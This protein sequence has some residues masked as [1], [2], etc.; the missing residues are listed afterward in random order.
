M[1]FREVRVKEFLRDSFR[2]GFP[3]FIA[4]S[5]AICIY[6]FIY[7]FNFVNSGISNIIKILMPFVYG[8]VIAY[9]LKRPYNF[10][11]EKMIKLLSEKRK[12]LAKLLAVI[13]VLVITIAL[14]VVLLMLVI[15]ALADS[16]VSIANQIPGLIDDLTKWLKEIDPEGTGIGGAIIQALETA[17]ENAVPWLK[18]NILSNISTTLSGALSTVT[19]ILGLLYNILIGVIICIYV[20]LG[21]DT[22]ARQ[23]KMLV[24][25]TFSRKVADWIIDEFI[26][27]DKTFNGFFAGKIL[28][29]AIVGIICFVFCVIL[30]FTLGLNNVILIS[31]VIGVTNIIPFFGPYI[32]GI[33][34]AILALM[35]GPVTCIVFALFIIVLQMVDGNFIGPR[36]LS[37]GVGLSG[38]WVLFA[39]TLFGGLM[40]FVGI[41][42]GVPIFAVIYDLIKKGVYFGLEK[43]GIKELPVRPKPVEEKK[44]KKRKKKPK[45]AE[46]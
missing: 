22:F 14:L 13:I 21:K 38:F 41:L 8:G 29:S 35:D 2:K 18:D 44:Q 20:L 1:V 42:V 15:P 40:G 27:I 5:L 45:V 25:A 16:L 37:S 11:E 28:D 34:C 31:V 17:E 19:G 3:L 39:I 33:P 7:R 46:A 12:G 10:F 23:A 36:C 9:L 4:L 26:F 32:G 24:Y 43:N 6:F 30:H